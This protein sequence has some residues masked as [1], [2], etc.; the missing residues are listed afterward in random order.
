M[1]NINLIFKGMI[2]GIAKIIPGVSGSLLAVS[3]GLYDRA[4]E[5]I[6]HPFKNFK[7]NMFFLGSLGLGVLIAITLCSNVVSFFLS[8]SFFLTVSLFVG[9]IIGSLPSFFKSIDKLSKKDYFL[10]FLVS[11]LVFL[12]SIFRSENNFVYENT[13]SKNILVFIFGFI[14][15]A[16]MVI[17]G[18]SGT[19][20]F[21]LLGCY[22]YVLELFSSVYN[23]FN[24]DVNFIPMVCF[25]LGI[26]IGIIIVSKIMN[27][28][29]KQHKKNTYLCIVGFA[30]SSILLLCMDL[31]FIGCSLLEFFIGIVL[32]ILGYKVSY[33]L[34][35]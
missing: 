1:L 23:I 10:V 28:M 32:F 29:L 6:S 21:L 34:N 33:K 26:L 24:F 3:L 4:I 17:P 11:I 25:A 35:N 2:I 19:A 12:L 31:F 30:I 27:Y 8:N 22:S 5:S 16:A 20:I 9:F 15:A 14:D 13:F 7:D 18:I